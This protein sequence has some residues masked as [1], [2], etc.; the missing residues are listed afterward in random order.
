MEDWKGLI[1]DIIS[2]SIGGIIVL[3][4]PAI[5]EGISK[6]ILI[7]VVL[8]VG[9]LVLNVY[10]NHKRCAKCSKKIRIAPSTITGEGGTESIL[11]ECQRDFYFMGIAANKW[12]KKA[13]NFDSTMKRI[14]A[15]HGE[16]RFIL[17][18]PMSKE[19][20]KISIAGSNPSDHLRHIISDNI[21]ALQTYKKMG[22]DVRVKVYSHMPIFRVA[23]VDKVEKVYVGA[24]EPS[25]NG[26]DMQQI[27]LDRN[28]NNRETENILKGQFLDYFE[29][30]WNDDSL[31]EIDIDLIENEEYLKNFCV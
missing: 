5:W 13:N 23:I 28:S 22:L 31:N 8:I 30:T 19:A 21:K 11:S 24:Y 16:V 2:N 7:Q 15:K 17:L 20:E 25:S 29:V 12:V 10:M 1:K 14:T 6:T 4:V 27:I 18:N 26:N 9:I 3:L